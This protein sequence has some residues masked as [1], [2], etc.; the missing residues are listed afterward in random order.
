MTDPLFHKDAAS[1]PQE[2]LFSDSSEENNLEDL[3]DRSPD[4]RN[5]YSSNSKKAMASPVKKSPRAQQKSHQKAKSFV[6]PAHQQRSASPK[7]SVSG[8]LCEHQM[9]LSRVAQF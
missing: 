7:S 9:D 1:Q 2:E 4:N 6:P 8:K 3:L 5:L